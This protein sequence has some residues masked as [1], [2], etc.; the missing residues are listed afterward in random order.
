MMNRRDEETEERG[1]P[2]FRRCTR[3][4][5]LS[6]TSYIVVVGSVA[7]PEISCDLEKWLFQAG[8]S[9]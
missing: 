3:L 8:D 9:V 7:A 6:K 4:N 2:N 5:H 1:K